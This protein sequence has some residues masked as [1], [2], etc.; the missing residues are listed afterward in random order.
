M[1]E[2]ENILEKIRHIR[3]TALDCINITDTITCRLNVVAD[4]LEKLQLKIIKKTGTKRNFGLNA[5]A[6]PATAPTSCTASNTRGWNKEERKMDIDHEYTQELVCPW[7]GY[8]FETSHEYFTYS[9]EGAANLEC[10]NCNE[11]FIAEMNTH[12]TYSTRK[13][14]IKEPQCTNPK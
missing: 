13:L 9:S 4:T 2:S 6:P 5:A 12:V 11:S 14:E 3:T 10:E 8:V 1:I 7:C